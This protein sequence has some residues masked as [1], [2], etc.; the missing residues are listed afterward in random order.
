MVL[1][2]TQCQLTRFVPET[3]VTGKHINLTVI[4]VHRMRTNRVEEV[5]VVTYH[6][7]RMF[8]IS[9]ILFQPHNRFHVEVI[10]RLIEQQIVGITIK[11]LCQH[12]THLFL[13]TQIAH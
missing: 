12:D 1:L 3:I 5:T 10:G 4:N 2:L 11:S 7:H 8:K 13:T 9:Q 6:Q